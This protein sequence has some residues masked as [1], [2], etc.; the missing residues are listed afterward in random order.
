VDEIRSQQQ[1]TGKLMNYEIWIL[2]E[3][4]LIVFGVAALGYYFLRRQRMVLDNEYAKARRLQT[5]VEQLQQRLSSRKR[6]AAAAVPNRDDL[7]RLR[8]D[9]DRAR[10]QLHRMQDGIGANPTTEQ[11]EQAA[12]MIE[13]LDRQLQATQDVLDR[14]LTQAASRQP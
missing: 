13:Q 12:A 4:M 14:A 11:Q 5:Q 1:T 8:G 7:A 9:V 3:A 10:D 2:I 6:G